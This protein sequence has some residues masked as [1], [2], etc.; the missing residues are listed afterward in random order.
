MSCEAV[1]DCFLIIIGAE[2]HFDA[3]IFLSWEIYGLK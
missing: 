1:I 3:I 2:F